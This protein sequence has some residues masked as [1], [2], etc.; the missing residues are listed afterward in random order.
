[1]RADVDYGGPRYT[2]LYYDILQPI[3]VWSLVSFNNHTSHVIAHLFLDDRHNIAFVF[4]TTCSFQHIPAQ[5]RP[6][7][8][9]T[10]LLNSLF[11][12]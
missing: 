5:Q 9:C 1:M 10:I 4:N 2:T 12:I 6:L 7:Q 8:H 3:T 11:E